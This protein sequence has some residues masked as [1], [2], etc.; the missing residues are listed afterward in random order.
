MY[1]ITLT[2]IGEKSEFDLFIANEFASHDDFA[3]IKRHEIVSWG[4]EGIVCSFMRDVLPDEYALKKIL[5]RYASL[6][7]K[8]TWI[9]PDGMAGLYIGRNGQ[10]RVYEWKDLSEDDELCF[11]SH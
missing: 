7:I 8:L 11:R 3:H 1:T 4:V 10:I 6:C 2:V 9:C 5:R